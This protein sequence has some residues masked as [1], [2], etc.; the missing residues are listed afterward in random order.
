MSDLTISPKLVVADADRAI[1]FYSAVLGAEPKSRF[2]VGDAVVFAALRV[3]DSIL[4]LK[5]A[6][7]HDPAPV[8][9]GCGVVLDVL[10]S[11]PDALMDRAVQHGAEVIFA[12]DDM[13]YGPRQGRFRDPF[14]HQW[15]VGTPITLTDEEVQSALDDLQTGSS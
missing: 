8:T 7:E 3:G 11:D 1:D 13:P 15:I 6:D 10:T 12:V 4:Q 14:G 9:G 5:D 2:V